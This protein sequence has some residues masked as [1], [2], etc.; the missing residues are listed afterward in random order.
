MGKILP[1]KIFA[2][3]ISFSAVFER[4]GAGLSEQRLGKA[5]ATAQRRS[6]VVEGLVQCGPSLDLHEQVRSKKILVSLGDDCHHHPRS[7]NMPL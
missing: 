3:I 4:Y 2:D 7:S 1:C 5:L 6:S